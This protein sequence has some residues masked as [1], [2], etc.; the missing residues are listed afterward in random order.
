LDINSEQLKRKK[1]KHRKNLK[2]RKEGT[3][4]SFL[5]LNSVADP[6]W[7]RIQKGKKEPTKIE[8]VDKFNIDVFF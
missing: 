5:F 2:N 3:G 4:T 7:I 1:P 8:Q 6:D